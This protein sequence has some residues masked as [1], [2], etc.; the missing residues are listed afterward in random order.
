MCE[1]GYAWVVSGVVGG[2]VFANLVVIDGLV[3]GFDGWFDLGFF[4]HFIMK[5]VL[6]NDLLCIFMYTTKH[7]KMKMFLVKKTI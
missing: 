7:Y 6:E 1:Y 2:Q 5:Q 4:F 3:P